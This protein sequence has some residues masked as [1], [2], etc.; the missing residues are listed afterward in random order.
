MKRAGAPPAARLARM[1][2]HMR[3]NKL[4]AATLTERLSRGAQIAAQV[5]SPPPPLPNSLP[6]VAWVS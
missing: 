1:E 4:R 3:E 5:P 6:G 2:Q